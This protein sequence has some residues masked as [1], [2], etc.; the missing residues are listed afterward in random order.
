MHANSYA[1]FE[2]LYRAGNISEVACMAYVRRKFV[3]VHRAQGSAIANEVI[4]RIA[5]L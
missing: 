2:D 3:D 4:R 5:Q 1:E